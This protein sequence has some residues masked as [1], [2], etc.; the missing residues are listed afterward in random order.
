[1]KTHRLIL[2]LAVVA[3]SYPAWAGNEPGKKSARNLRSAVMKRLSRTGE[4][5]G[6]L[7]VYPGHGGPK[8]HRASI[9]IGPGPYGNT[10]ANVQAIWEKLHPYGKTDRMP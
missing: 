3:S 5:Q 4:F 2:A 6:Y 10:P 1:M 7:S 9:S 8:G